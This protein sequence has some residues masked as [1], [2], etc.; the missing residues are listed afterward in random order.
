MEKSDAIAAAAVSSAAASDENAPADGSD[1]LRVPPYRDAGFYQKRKK[2]KYRAVAAPDL[3]GPVADTHTHIQMLPDQA[4]ELARCAANGVDFLCVVSDPAEDALDVFDHLAA[5]Q[6]QAP[7]ALAEIAPGVDASHLPHVR[8]AVGVHPHNAR[9]YD[10]AMEKLLY[11]L[12]ADQ[13]VAALGEI[14][15]DYHYDF[16]PRESQR[17]VFARQLEIARELGFPVSLHIREAHGE[18]LAIL[19]EVGFPSAGTL[20]HCCALP[21]EELRPWVEAGCYIA[22]GGPL[23]FKK[24]D[25]VR[26]AVSIVPEDRLLI[27]TDAPYMTPEPMRGVANTPAHVVFTAARLAEVRGVDCGP[28]RGQ[29]LAALEANARRLLDRPCTPYQQAHEGEARG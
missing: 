2:G 21:R 17:R 28:D 14:G 10:D 7:A 15:L 12:L 5:W 18:A 1:R 29:F 3:E 26:E 19:R 22:Y 23:T 27:E 9:L 24:A 13:R 8:L 25:E 11:R 16:S 4:L 6:G 20:L